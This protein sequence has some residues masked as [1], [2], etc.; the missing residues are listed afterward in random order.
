MRIVALGL[1]AA[2]LMAI[3][4][5]AA[6]PESKAVAVL[7]QVRQSP[8]F[9]TAPPGTSLQGGYVR[10][11]T[12][13][14]DDGAAPDAASEFTRPPADVTDWFTERFRADGWTPT[15]GGG[16]KKSIDGVPIRASI[17]LDGMYSTHEGLF[18]VHATYDGSRESV[19]SN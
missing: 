6:S 17:D 1:V 13:D 2:A 9:A 8:P 19:C 3:T 7:E 16:F 11:C 15:G 10:K 14:R 5:C 4:S 12:G 18:T